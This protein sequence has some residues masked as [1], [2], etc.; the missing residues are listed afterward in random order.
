MTLTDTKIQA[1]L[2]SAH[3]IAKMSTC[4]FTQ[5][6]CVII[7]KDGQPIS[8]GYN[9]T[10]P[11]KKHCHEYKMTSDEH[12]AFSERYEIHAEMNALLFASDRNKL[13]GA[14]AFTTI[15]PCYNCLKHM[16]AVGISKVY[17]SAKYWRLTDQDLTDMSNDFPEIEIVCN[18][19]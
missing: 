13:K 3:A 12:K 11:G 1:Y 15:T 4:Q 18:H 6:G 5:V 2:E 7:S 14:I 8:F 19:K 10:G 9:G 17:S 16:A